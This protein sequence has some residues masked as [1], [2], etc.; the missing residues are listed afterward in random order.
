MDRKIRK[1]LILN[2]MH[3][4]KADVNRMYVRRK[5][6]G[7]GMIN[8]EMCF[9]TTTVGLNTYSLSSDD[10][11]LVLQHEKKKKFHSVTKKSRRFK[12]QL[13]ITQKENEQT[14]KLL[15]LQKRLK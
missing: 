15:K 13:N 1:L 12:F 7:R 6:G 2:R 10:R 3:H 14:S 11:M 5:E 8:P 4:P 9:K